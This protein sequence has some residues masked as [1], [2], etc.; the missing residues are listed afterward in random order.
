MLGSEAVFVE[1]DLEILEVGHLVAHSGDKLAVQFG[2]LFGELEF[3][4]IDGHCFEGVKGLKGFFDCFQFPGQSVCFCRRTSSARIC[5]R[6]IETSYFGL[7]SPVIYHTPFAQAGS[8]YPNE[9]A[10]CQMPDA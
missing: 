10:I 2:R 1:F 5:G 9:Q 8:D 7:F 6:I 4:D 3:V